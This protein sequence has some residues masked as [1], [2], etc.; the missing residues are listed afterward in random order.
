[1]KVK[2][3]LF[4]LTFFLLILGV[5]NSQT[6]SPFVW[7]VEKGGKVS[8]FLGSTHLGVSL[9]EMP[10]FD[11]VLVRI[12]NSDL[13]F[14]E[15]KNNSD[16]DRLSEEEQD[17][18]FVGT[19]REREG[20]LSRLS[21]E[22]REQIRERRKLLDNFLKDSLPF[23][24]QSSIDN[25]FEKLSPRSQNFLIEYGA[26]ISGDYTDFFHFI[27]LIVFYKA[28]VLLPSLDKQ[29]VKLAL[30]RSIEIKSLDDSKKIN[31]NFRP[32][33]SSDKSI[34]VVDHTVIDEIVDKIDDLINQQAEQ[35][36][37]EAQTYKMYDEDLFRRMEWSFSEKT[38]FKNRNQ[39]WLKKFVKV[40]GKYDSIFLVAGIGHLLGPHNILDMLK[41]E[42]FSVERMTCHQ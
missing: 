35:M 5:A 34:A 1:M 27:R 37:K 16:F 2:N 38:F 41:E 42:G 22:T 11:K 39:L 20:I 31:E 30:P 25:N 36:L 40:H 8:Y 17:K 6:K 18:L 32:Q 29:I 24:I 33:P 23:D 12:K 14:L 13:L 19:K 21:P 10:C 7:L 26:D 3:F 4:L 28:S 15:A 9:E